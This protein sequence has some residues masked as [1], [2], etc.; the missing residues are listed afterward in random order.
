MKSD[1]RPADAAATRAERGPDLVVRGGRIVTPD[2]IVDAD[3]A[4]MEGCIVRIA[5]GL[6]DDGG[7]ALDARGKF[8]FP[9]IVDAH[10]HFNE[11]GR[12]KWEDFATGSAALAAGGGTCFFDQPSQCVPL[13]LDAAALREKRRLAEEKSC[14]DFAL[15]GGLAP[16][17]LDQLAALRDAGSVGVKAY[18]GPGNDPVFPVV[19]ADVLREGMKRAAKLG[20]VVS[21]HAEDAVMI[22]S[23]PRTKG[24]RTAA[25]WAS[26]R[27]M[28]AEL[29]AIRLALEL[30][31]ETGC[32]LHV[33]SVSSPEGLDLIDEARQMRVDVT[34]EV[35]APHLLLNAA[36]VARLGVAAKNAPPIRDEEGRA[37]LWRE[38]RAGRVQAVASAHSPAPVEARPAKDFSGAVAGIAGCQHSFSLLISEV[39]ATAD[40]DLPML[41]AVL[42]R[43]VARRFRLDAHKGSLAP[44][45]DADFCLVEIGAAQAIKADELWTRQR[46]SVYVGRKSRARITH[47]YVRGVPVFADGRLVNFAPPGRFLRPTHG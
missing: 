39:A 3:L 33:A 40:R 44:G 28:E 12:T 10:V 14:I 16:G 17:N 23:A 45:K 15:W 1:R 29:A 22:A 41:A 31:G 42:A 37:G 27:P 34:A 2:G 47:T 18:L 11:P 24:G 7:Q 32:V 6:L 25:A 19:D 13:T 43:N 4:V 38:L 21:V 46:S 20:L 30:A 26:S 36:D 35:A 8:V 9:G 5:P